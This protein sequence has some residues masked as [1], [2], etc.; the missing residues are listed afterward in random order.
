MLS[1]KPAYSHTHLPGFILVP[2]RTFT[3][4]SLHKYVQEHINDCRRLAKKYVEEQKLKHKLDSA[5][6]HK[7]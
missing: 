7:H 3:A 2:A 6:K 1:Q 5:L 4:E